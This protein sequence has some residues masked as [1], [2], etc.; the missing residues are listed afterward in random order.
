MADPLTVLGGVAAALQIADTFVKIGHV[1]GDARDI[2]DEIEHFHASSMTMG[3][4]LPMVV[5][6]SRRSLKHV[7]IERVAGQKSVLARLVL[8]FKHVQRRFSYLSRQITLPENLY[9][10]E[11]STILVR[12]RLRCRW[13]RRRSA[14]TAARIQQNAT[15]ISALLFLST[16]LLEDNLAV[17]ENSTNTK[18]SDFLRDLLDE[19]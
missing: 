18:D 5:N 6:A 12:L 7:P 14:I 17:L 8:E 11:D 15:K 9:H 16:L 3:E 19:M 2:S 10:P 4:L 1:F 13:F